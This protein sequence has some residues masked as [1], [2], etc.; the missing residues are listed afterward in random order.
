V[1]PPLFALNQGP[2]PVRS[3]ANGGSAFT[4]VGTIDLRVQKAF[5]VGRAEVAAV[6]DVYNLPTLDNEVIEY[7]VT[8]PRFRTPTALQP[9]RTVLVGARMSF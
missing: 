8:G 1:I 6:M 2:A 9:P 4:F 7:V 5:T 3:Y